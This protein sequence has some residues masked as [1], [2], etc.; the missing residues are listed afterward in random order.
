[1]LGFPY[2]GK[3]PNLTGRLH[4]WLKRVEPRGCTVRSACGSQDPPPAVG[5]AK[6]SEQRQRN[7]EAGATY[8]G[9]IGIM[10]DKMETILCGGYMWIMEK[11]TETIL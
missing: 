6:G 1:M 7:D 3:L 4:T 2:F 11:S 10:E 5:N 9:K 8:W